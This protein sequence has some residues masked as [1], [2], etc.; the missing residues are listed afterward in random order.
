MKEEKRKRANTTKEKQSL[1]YQLFDLEYFIS[2]DNENKICFD[3]GGPFPT[4]VSINNGVFI[5]SNCSKNH[6][7]LGYNISYIYQINSPWDQYLLSYVLRGG[8]SRFKQLCQEYDVP[9]QSFDENDEEKLNKYIIELGNYHRLT[10]RSEILAEEPPKSLSFD[11]A[12]KK[13]NLDIILFPELN[14]YH[15]YKGEMIPGKTTF[16]G[17]IWKGTKVTAKFIGHKGGLIFKTGK[18]ILSNG[19]SKGIKY[20]G[21]HIWNY[22]SNNGDKKKNKDKID[23]SDYESVKNKKI[24]L[25]SPNNIFNDLSNGEESDEEKNIEIKCSPKHYAQIVREKARLRSF[26]K[27]SEEMSGAAY[28]DKEDTGELFQ[29]AEAEFFRL[30]QERSTGDMTPIGEVVVKAIQNVESAYKNR[31]A[32]TGIATG[33]LDLDYKTAGLQPS[34]LILIAARPSMGKTAFVL[35]LAS[36]IAVKNK[37]PTAVFSL[38]MNAVQL[39]NRLLAMHS[40]VD[41]QK[42]RTGNLE[43]SNWN[44]LVN[45]ARV[46]GESAL[47]I[48]DTPGISIQELRSKCRKM[49]LEKNLQLVIIDY[50]QLMSGGKNSDSRQQQVSEISRSLK[51]LAREIN[52]PVIALSQ[53]SREVEKRDDKRPILSDL[54]DSGAIEQDADVVMFLYRDEYYHKDS[55]KPG[56]TEVIIGKQR[57][58]PIGTVELGWVAN[59]TRF[60]NLDRSKGNREEK[61]E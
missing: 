43:D 46:L 44:D 24:C 35:N 52:C 36:H 9:C 10:L 7:K 49:K 34:D 21:K 51:A 26:I 55:K 61:S 38:E 4:Y 17:K 29:R 27:V 57:Q 47:M 28:L 22:H 58:G 6:E 23:I 45:S 56:I 25:I 60:V 5:C 19:T 32:V 30:F 50:L 53:L 48:D 14:D 8:N 40:G 37:I 12:T 13:C 33:F 18:R 31:G 41:A 54:R 3:C 15:L 11:D 2:L 39:A 1:N 59:L 20:I 16:G 42:I